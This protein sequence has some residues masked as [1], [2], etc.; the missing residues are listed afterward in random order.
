MWCDN[1][2]LLFPLRG[3]AMVLAGLVALYSIAGAVFLFLYGDFLYFT[4]PE[5]QLYGGVGIAAGLLAVLF[6]IAL[7][8]NSY[9][10]TRVLAYLSPIVLFLLAV[11]AGLMIFRLDYYMYFLTWRFKVWLEKLYFGMRNNGA[12]IYAA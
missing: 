5:P 4:Y 7:S 2:L 1:C 11:R 9:M 6:I 3:G 10:W 8:N 12:G